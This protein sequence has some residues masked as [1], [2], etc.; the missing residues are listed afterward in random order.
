[1]QASKS[2]VKRSFVVP[3]KQFSLVTFPVTLASRYLQKQASIPR[4]R[5][6]N[7]RRSDFPFPVPVLMVSRSM[8]QPA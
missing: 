2:V 5:I 6:F 4:L 1:M 8:L 7:E 3:E